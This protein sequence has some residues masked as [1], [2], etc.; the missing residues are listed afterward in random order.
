M[1][2]DVPAIIR[3]ICQSP[4]GMY[5]DIQHLNTYKSTAVR[6]A[7]RKSLYSLLLIICAQPTTL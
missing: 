2:L 7:G 3:E 1:S 6:N 5:K 4:A